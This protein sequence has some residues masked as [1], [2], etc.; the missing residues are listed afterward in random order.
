[1]TRILVVGVDGTADSLA[2]LGSAAELAEESGAT[3][4]VVHVRHESGMAAEGFGVGAEA[5]MSGALDQVEKTSRERTEDVPS[6]RSLG[7]SRL[8]LVTRPPS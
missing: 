3:L 7:G 5:A 4:V 6:G 2:A 8:A 1:M